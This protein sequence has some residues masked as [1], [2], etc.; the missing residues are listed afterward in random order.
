MQPSSLTQDYHLFSAVIT[1]SFLHSSVKHNVWLMR[2]IMTQFICSLDT[3]TLP[4][5]ELPNFSLARQFNF[6]LFPHHSLLFLPFVLN[7][8][9][10]MQNQAK[11]QNFLFLKEH[12]LKFKN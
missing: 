2:C 6:L 12:F 11:K 1:Y 7:I 9:C 5:L 3:I 4:P 10:R 8:R